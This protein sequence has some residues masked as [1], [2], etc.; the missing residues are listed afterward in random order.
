MSKLALF[1][2]LSISGLCVSRY[3]NPTPQSIQ[4]FK[5]WK[6]GLFMH[7]GIYANLGPMPG[8]GDV[9]SWPLSWDARSW[10][11]KNVTTKDDMVKFRKYY[12][13]LSQKFNP[14]NFDPSVWADAA[15]AAGMRYFI[16]VHF[17]EFKV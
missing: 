3:A 8:C 4:K 13:G 10:A 5:Q 2:V 16:M 17:F 11:N 1:I 7:W 9:C 14:S 6:F 15:Y 12:W